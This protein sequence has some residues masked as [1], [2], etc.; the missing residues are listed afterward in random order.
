LKMIAKTRKY[1]NTKGISMRGNVHLKEVRV[2]VT[3]IEKKAS[4]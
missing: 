1:E 3:E 2:E 4:V